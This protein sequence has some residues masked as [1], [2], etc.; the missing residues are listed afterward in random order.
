MEAD[1]IPPA[2]ARRIAEKLGV[3]VAFLA[4]RFERRV[5]GWSLL[6]GYRLARWRRAANNKKRAIST[7]QREGKDG[8]KAPAAAPPP[9]LQSH[10]SEPV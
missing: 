10:A 7:T 8:G 4:L 6:G 3:P 2:D 5:T 1:L 9:W